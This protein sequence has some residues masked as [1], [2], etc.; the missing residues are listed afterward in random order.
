MKIVCIRHQV[1]L[2]GIHASLRVDA[3]ILRY[4]VAPLQVAVCLELIA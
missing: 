2:P 4:K 3:T 1:T